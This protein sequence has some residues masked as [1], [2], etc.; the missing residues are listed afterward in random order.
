M[1]CPNC[2]KEIKT[3]LMSSNQLVS[4]E[5]TAA[6]N[7]IKGVNKDGYCE[8]CIDL[9]SDA[10]KILVFKKVEEAERFIKS[11]IDLLP[12]TTLHVPL[13]WKYKS[14]GVVTAKTVIGTGAFTEIASGFTDFFGGKSDAMRDKLSKA[15]NETM[16][17]LRMEAIKK[18]CN[19]IA[20]MSLTY[21][22]VG[23]GK[24]MLLVTAQGTAIQL[25]NFSEVI[26]AEDASLFEQIT[27]QFNEIS[28]LKAL[29]S[30]L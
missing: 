22:E 21:G 30:K 13:N 9:E 1:N 20:G 27:T 3:G 6:L 17:M 25:E 19:A 7:R 16:S 12:I 4:P 11:K 28:E 14:H 2:D 8:R 5:K 23:S 15:E 18:K 26:N 10:A 24:G 29:K